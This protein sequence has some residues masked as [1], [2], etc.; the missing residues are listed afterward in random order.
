M[1]RQTDLKMVDQKA[2]LS[3]AELAA[4]KVQELFVQSDWLKDKKPVDK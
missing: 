4:T 3:V 1:V 2:V